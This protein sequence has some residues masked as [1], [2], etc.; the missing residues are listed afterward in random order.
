MTGEE[1][2]EKYRPQHLDE[3][4][5]QKKIIEELREWAATWE[6]GMPD[7]RAVILYGRAGVG[8]TT[9]AHALG[10][11][12]RWDTIELNASDSR[13]ADVINKVAGSASQMCT[14]GGTRGRRLIILDEADNIHGSADRGGAN[15]VIKVIG[16]TKQPM[17]LIANEYYDMSKTLRDSCRGI[18]FK[19]IRAT[20]I[21]ALIKK[22]AT[23]EHVRI[24]HGAA[25]TIATHSNGDVR[26][27]INDLQAIAEG[28]N[29]ILTKDITVSLRDS[30]ETV[31]QVISKIFKGSN[32]REAHGLTFQLDETPED[33][34]YWIDEN[35]PIVYKDP[36]D[37]T[38]SFEVL[39]KADIFLGRVRRREN[40]RMWKHASLLMSGG[41]AVS[42]THHYI[43]V[44]LRP[45]STW[46][47]LARTRSIRKMQDSISLKI[48]KHCHT[49]KNFARTEL[50]NFIK[51]LMQDENSATQIAAELDF[52]EEEI[53]HILQTKTTDKKVKKIYKAARTTIKKEREEGIE[54]YAG[55]THKTP[56]TETQ[57]ITREKTTEKKYNKD[58]EETKNGG[59]TQSTLFD[60]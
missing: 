9:A 24:E 40:Y 4:I 54:Y 49:S 18:R 28:R 47:R 22:I 50:T 55:T 45:P 46:Q 26:S 58:K 10:R 59:K 7:E 15:A 6:Q 41:I 32:L 35:L 44:R 3:I 5:G 1:W 21:T 12:F 34:I 48:G 38:N 8:K 51:T 60:F 16:E 20:T 11:D 31:F 53:A 13:T 57:K 19:A 33:L 30:K 43:G 25:E 29:E 2:T 42:K 27:A 17:I 14:F 52:A 39:S 56:K 36:V 37:L 23:S